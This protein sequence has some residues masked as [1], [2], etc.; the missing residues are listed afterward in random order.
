MLTDAEFNLLNFIAMKNE[1]KQRPLS[2]IDMLCWGIEHIVTNHRLQ[3]NCDYEN[4]GQVCIWGGCNVPTLSDVIMLCE[5]VGIDR[6]CIS[7]SEFGIEVD[8]SEEWY[9][10][11]AIKP[12]RK[13]LELWKR[14]F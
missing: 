6:Q 11:H 2:N 9:E 12:Y 4:D 7:S 14:K 1:S 3:Y 5:D 8:I 13:G 10:E